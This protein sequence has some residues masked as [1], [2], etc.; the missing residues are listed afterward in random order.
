MAD[1]LS[2]NE[3]DEL[4]SAISTGVVSA[5]N[6]K[7]EQKQKKIKLYDFKRPDKFSKDQIR[8]LYMLH[9][10]FARLL[11]TYLSAHLRTMVQVSV[12]SVDQLTYEEFIRSMPNPSVISIFE[13]RPL[14]GNALME[15][16]PSIVFSIIDR[17]FGGVGTPPAK[18]R[19]LTDI[20]QSIV[21]RIVNK[22][23]ESLQEAWRQVVTVEPRL[24]A[25]ESN[26][27]FTQIVPPNDMVVIITLQTRIAQTEGFINLCIPYLVLEP[28]MPKLTTSFWVA[29]SIARA[30]SQTNATLLQKKLERT[31]VPLM[32]EL[33]K[34]SVTVGEMLDL[35]VGDVVR[36]DTRVN[37]ELSV[38]I[39]QQQKFK[40][41]PGSSNN[42]IAIQ[43]TRA[44]VEEDDGHE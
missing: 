26:P 32:V 16:N 42:R 36:L 37:E 6:I 9:E 17:L 38:I 39:G 8:T 25:I 13:M 34:V 5:E 2:Q 27:Q 43:I 41:K 11:N 28:I 21:A 14:S 20:E 18:S 31:L 15:I 44:V 24:E 30:G 23:L 12:A 3:I 35:T 22:A 1:V 19:E 4:L 7:Q 40:C 10:N 29:S 33:G